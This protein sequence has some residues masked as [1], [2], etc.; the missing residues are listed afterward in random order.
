M[1][2]FRKD[3][4]HFQLHHESKNMP[5]ADHFKAAL[6]DSLCDISSLEFDTNTVPGPRTV[7]ATLSSTEIDCI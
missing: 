3:I 4:R 6:P 7:I 5:L 2:R 1:R